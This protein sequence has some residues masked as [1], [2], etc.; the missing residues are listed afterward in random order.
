MTKLSKVLHLFTRPSLLSYSILGFA[1][2]LPF[3]LVSSTVSIWLST[4]GFSLTTIGLIFLTTVP[5]SLKFLWAPFLDRLAIPK[6]CAF[7]G[8]RKGWAIAG[9]IG[10]FFSLVALAMVNPTQQCILTAF[11]IFL[12]SFFA[13]TQDMS[14]DAFRIEQLSET[15]LPIAVSLG[16]IGFRTGMLI[17]GA[18][19][20]YW[21]SLYSWSLVFWISAILV[22]LGPLGMVFL[23][24]KNLTIKENLP[25]SSALSYFQTLWSALKEF[26]DRKDW[27]WIIAFIFVYKA[28]D[29]IPHAMGGPL[30]IDLNF[31]L[32]EIAFVAKAFGVFIMILG[33][34]VGGILI[35]VYGIH[36]GIFIS[37]IAQIFP[38]FTFMLLALMGHH[39]P[40]LIFTIT[41]QNF[42]CGLGAPAF[43]TFLTTLCTKRLTATQFSI[44]YS[45]GSLARI[46]FSAGSGWFADQFSWVLFFSLVTLL[47]IPLL[48]IVTR[49]NK[50]AF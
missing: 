11:I 2:G 20:L 21:A 50:E 47:G 48:W 12:I 35:S 7:Y 40:T 44:L 27:H 32:E 45:L 8:Q 38:P 33:G 25:S 9:Q 4:L 17:G 3:I 22:L 29:A 30:L 14:L 23:K 6:L 26:I 10:L 13:A 41:I 49:L 18:G 43:Y 19:T 16:G 39:S 24:E 36:R 15:E 46:L 42:C 34:I 28:I 5:Y 37:A 31:N 1:S